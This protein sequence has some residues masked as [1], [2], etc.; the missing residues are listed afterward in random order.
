MFIH[1]ENPALKAWNRHWGKQIQVQIMKISFLWMTW[2]CLD[3]SV[4]SELLPHVYELFDRKTLLTVLCKH[5][6]GYLFPSLL[7]FLVAPLRP[8]AGHPTCLQFTDNMMTA[9]RTYQWQC[10]E[11]K[12]CSLCGTSEND[13]SIPWPGEGLDEISVFKC[14]HFLLIL[15]CVKSNLTCFECG[16]LSTTSVQPVIGN[17]MLNLCQADIVYLMWK[18][19][20][21]FI[22]FPQLSDWLI[23]YLSLLFF[24]NKNFYYLL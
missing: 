22:P 2:M 18:G 4:K 19:F 9:V 17:A 6:A 1:I 5:T 16:D 23:I 24:L 7:T 13:V 10:I 20:F 11:C 8:F 14:F 12:S 15:L 3:V 21:F